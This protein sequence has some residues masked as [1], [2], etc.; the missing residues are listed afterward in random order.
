MC[1]KYWI[2]RNIL[3]IK[4]RRCR[5]SILLLI[6]LCVEIFPVYLW[7]FCVN[8]EGWLQFIDNAMSIKNWLADLLP[9][10]VRLHLEWKFFLY[11]RIVSQT[12][13]LFSASSSRCVDILLSILFNFLN[14]QFKHDIFIV[15]FYK[16]TFRTL[17]ILPSLYFFWKIYIRCIWPFSI[18]L[19]QNNDII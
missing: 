10:I 8:E 16:S 1:Y 6:F 2:H 18:F 5:W 9:S 17:L 14:T 12:C 7:L 3:L 11:V 15:L 19:L 13:S 4:G